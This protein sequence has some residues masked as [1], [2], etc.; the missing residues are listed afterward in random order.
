MC[1]KFTQWSRRVFIK[2][3]DFWRWSALQELSLDAMCRI[4]HVWMPTHRVRS[5]LKLVK[6]SHG[7]WWCFSDYSATLSEFD[8]HTEMFAA[9]HVFLKLNFWQLLKT[10]DSVIL[11]PSRVCVANG[12]TTSA[13]NL[14]QRRN[15]YH[16]LLLRTC[17]ELDWLHWW[18][19][20]RCMFSDYTESSSVSWDMTN[21]ADSSRKWERFKQRSHALRS[22][23]VVNVPQLQ[24]H[25]IITQ[26]LENGLNY[27]YFLSS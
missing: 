8:L 2:S 25:Q 23:C 7:L 20:C 6:C 27:K 26:Q 24:S 21:W 14:Q 15:N 10:F 1:E 22:T 12:N 5:C 11:V 18:N 4:N 17:F 3:N 9:K 16:F 19:L 13:Q